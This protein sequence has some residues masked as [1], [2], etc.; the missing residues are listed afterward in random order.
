MV[1]AITG[2]AVSTVTA[3]GMHHSHN[4][5]KLL[6]DMSGLDMTAS[7]LMGEITSATTPEDE[8]Y[9]CPVCGMSTKDMGYD[10]L[11]YIDFANGQTVYTCGMAARSHK[12]Y[13]IDLTDTAYLA[14]NMAEFIVNSSATEEYAECENS[15]EECEDGIKDPVTGDD[16]TTSNYQYVCLTNGQKL[17]FAS[18]A[19]KDKYLSNVN[20]KPRYLV[21][22]IICENKTCS[23]AENITV[24]SAAAEAFT[25]DLTTVN[26]SDSSFASDSS[27]ATI[28]KSSV[29][30]ILAIVSGGLAVLAAMA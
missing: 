8:E 28:V 3:H 21:D 17:Y 27:D 18:T 19:S 5:R 14:A 22:S 10:N 9:N 16:V 26:S 29:S 2:A 4:V 11:N 12:D 6:A 1:V 24:L 30:L 15:C 25:P 7:S 20:T 23:D 13:E